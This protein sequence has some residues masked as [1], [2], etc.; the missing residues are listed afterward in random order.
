MPIPRTI[1]DFESPCSA[2][3]RVNDSVHCVLCGSPNL[4]Y[5]AFVS[6]T[7]TFGD[8]S[9]IQVPG[10]KCRRCGKLFAED[11][12][13]YAPKPK[14]TTEQLVAER[15]R[16]IQESDKFKYPGMSPEQ[17]KAQKFKDLFGTERP[18]KQPS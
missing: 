3:G 4:S 9:K 17:I 10:F 2:C 18:Q 16:E 11:D 14:L 5:R 1:K 8:G 7:K 6:Y 15:F 13:C 12:K